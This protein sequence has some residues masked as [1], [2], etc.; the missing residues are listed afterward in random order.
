MAGL[1]IGLGFWLS[2]TVASAF[3]VKGFENPALVKL[4]FGAVFP[5]GLIAVCIAGADLW[6]GNVQVIPYGVMMKKYGFRALL[7]NWLVSYAGNFIGGVFLAFVASY[8]TSLLVVEPTYSL[9]T[10]V[11]S[12]KVSLDPWTAFWRGVGCNLLVNLAIWMWLRSRKSD[13]M[14]Q[15]FLIW[16]P[17]FCF[18]ALGLEHSIANMFGVPAGIYAAAMKGTVLATHWQF[19][20]NNLLPVTFGNL[21]GGFIFIA[22]YYWYVG[23]TKGSKYGEAKPVDALKYFGLA[24]A[25]GLILLALLVVVPGAIAFAIE[26]ALGLEPGSNLSIPQLMLVPAIAISIY[27]IA[28]AFAAYK[29]VKP[30]EDALKHGTT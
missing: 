3:I 29:V 25:A 10:K 17:I 4:L 21:I 8:G 14:G 20:F 16:F 15:A 6:T 1:Y 7:Y 28:V 5:V 11:A 18:V 19:M 26:K 22:L 23:F 13:F 27:D 9:I 2:S 30:V 12:A 24:V